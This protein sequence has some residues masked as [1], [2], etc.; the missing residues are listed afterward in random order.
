V[1]KKGAQ[2]PAP[3]KANQLKKGEKPP[4]A[5]QFLGKEEQ[6]KK[7]ASSEDYFQKLAT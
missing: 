1:D 2:K 6:T 7:V 3:K 4:R 5:F